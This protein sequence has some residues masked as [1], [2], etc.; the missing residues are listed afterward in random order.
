MHGHSTPEERKERGNGMESGYVISAGP[1]S[2]PE[3]GMLSLTIC[4]IVMAVLQFIYL[5]ACV[6]VCASRAC[7]V[8][9]E[10]RGYWSPWNWSYEYL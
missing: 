3:A 4:V 9:S 6:Y 10:V 1:G 7:L 8:S 2:I 5:F